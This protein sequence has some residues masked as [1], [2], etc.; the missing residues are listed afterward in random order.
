MRVRIEGFAYGGL[1]LGRAADGHAESVL[2]PWVLPGEQ[3]DVVCD[4]GGR[5]AELKRLVETSPE[6]VAPRC[7]HFGMCGGCHL[8][9]GSEAEQLRLKQGILMDSLRRAGVQHLPD[10]QVHAGEPWGYRNRIRLRLQQLQQNGGEL[11]FGYTRRGEGQVFLPISTCPIA[12][13]L[14]WRAAESMLAVSAENRD[15]AAWLSATREVEL[16]TNADLSRLGITLLCPRDSQPIATLAAGQ[17]EAS[18]KRAMSALGERLPELTGAG[19]AA[20]TWQPLRLGR[21]LATW[22]ASGLAYT[23]GEESYWVTR[24]GFFQVNRFLLPGLVELVC[25]H[26]AGTLVWDLFAG[27]GLFSRVLAR[28]FA[29]VV[30]VEAHPGSVNELRRIL[31]RLNGQHRAEGMTV[32]SFLQGA[33]LQ[34]DRPDLIVL[35]PPRAGAGAEVCDLLLRVAAPQITYVSCD[36]VTL[37]RDLTVLGQGYRVAALHLLDLFP[38]TYHQEAVVTLH[39]RA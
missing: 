39:R 16:F 2:V 12:A 30:A 18:F 11:R 25:D 38:Q 3:A 28:S 14:L 34:R 21:A 8:Q 20:T 5:Q 1:G 17:R 15:L 13:P 32:L 9:M 22:G 31:E 36:P 26:M 4:P 19:A 10:P 24:G 37:G 7:P 23:V 29:T 27:V 35:D 6:R 33:V